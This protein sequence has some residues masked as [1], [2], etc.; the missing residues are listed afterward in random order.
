MTMRKSF[1]GFIM[2]AAVLVSLILFLSIYVT[3]SGFYDQ[4]VRQSADAVSNTLARGTFNAMYQIMRRGWTRPQLEEFIHAIQSNSGQN[5]YSI[6]IYRGKLVT[7][8]FGAIKQGQLDSAVENTFEVGEPNQLQQADGM[9][10]TYPLKARNEC[11]RCH[12][13]ARKGDTLG[14]IEVKQNLGPVMRNARRELLGPLAFI[15]PIPLLVALGV[16]LFMNSRVKRSVK[17]LQDDI[18]AVSHVADLKQIETQKSDLGF[19]ELNQIFGKG[20]SEKLGIFINL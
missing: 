14:V 15:T 10:Y 4:A 16:A 11:L 2:T 6:D 8:R 19:T 7:Q 1:T 13:N 20:S 17:L 18:D 3:A 9:V 12:T 5:R